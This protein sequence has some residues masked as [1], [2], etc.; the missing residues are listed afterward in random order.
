VF[1][2]GLRDL[3]RVL[4]ARGRVDGVNY[5][6]AFIVG[7]ANVMSDCPEVLLVFRFVAGGLCLAVSFPIIGSGAI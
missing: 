2:P 3:S 6:A 7:A 1:S 5:L 4:A